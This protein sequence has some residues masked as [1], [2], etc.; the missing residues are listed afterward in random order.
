MPIEDKAMFIIR[1]YL[2]KDKDSINRLAI[3]AFTQFKDQYN[4][5]EYIKSVVGNMTSL[6]DTSDLIVAEIN[7]EIVGAVALVHPGKDS[8]KNIVP[9][10]ASIRMLVVSPNHRS[11]GIGK[12]LA[13]EC[14]NISRSRNFKEI[15]LFTSPIMKVALPMYLRMGFEKLKDIEPISGVDYA[16]YKLDL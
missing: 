12:Q 1:P 15:A 5:W 3:E 8:N 9:S 16:L 13:L 2:E 7:N 11:K 6:E 14:L 4:D 10:W